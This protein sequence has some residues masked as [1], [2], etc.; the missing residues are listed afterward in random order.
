[1]KYTTVSKEIRKS[2]V[3][4]LVESFRSNTSAL[5]FH[6][7]NIQKYFIHLRVE[8]CAVFATCEILL[9]LYGEISDFN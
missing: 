4:L 2:M 6:R 1:M 5:M 9:N 8:C 7:L 3:L